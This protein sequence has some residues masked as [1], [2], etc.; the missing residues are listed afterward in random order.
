M[1]LEQDLVGIII[2][3]LGDPIS[4]SKSPPSTGCDENV[5]GHSALVSY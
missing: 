1:Y 5:V 2:G 3:M 4:T